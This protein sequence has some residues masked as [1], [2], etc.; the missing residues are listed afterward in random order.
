MAEVE[1]E[2]RNYLPETERQMVTIQRKFDINNTV[3]TYL[4]EKRAEAGIAKASN[5]SD[6]KIIDKAFLFNS[7]NL[8]PQ[9]R[10]NYIMALNFRIN[11]PYDFNFPDRL[12]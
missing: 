10:Q 12:F 3:Y 11:Y 1:S 6:N 8:K 2:V 9:T 7:S 5:V 4:L